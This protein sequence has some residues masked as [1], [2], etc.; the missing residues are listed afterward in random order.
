[1][2]PSLR[3]SHQSNLDFVKDYGHVDR[4]PSTQVHQAQYRTGL[5]LHGHW[6]RDDL[7]KREDDLK[8]WSDENTQLNKDKGET[9]SSLRE[10]LRHCR[11]E[12]TDA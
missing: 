4:I 10:A 1:M 3:R 12:A 5:Q 2:S 9:V 7:K 11:V 6:V 8:K